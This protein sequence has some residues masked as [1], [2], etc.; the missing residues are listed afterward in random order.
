MPPKRGQTQAPSGQSGAETGADA[1][2]S[3]DSSASGDAETVRQALRTLIVVANANQ[4]EEE[5]ME[6]YP[7]GYAMCA[8]KVKVGNKEEVCGHRWKNN[9]IQASRN[10]GHMVKFHPDAWQEALESVTAQGHEQAERAQASLNAQKK[11]IRD[12]INSASNRTSTDD[13]FVNA[14]AKNA[15]AYQAIED[16]DFRALPF[17]RTLSSE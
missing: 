4:V 2:T 10:K 17:C 7:T 8:V 3:V 9:S 11:K 16:A 5:L 12:F 14:F 1:D 15:L 13:L 6:R